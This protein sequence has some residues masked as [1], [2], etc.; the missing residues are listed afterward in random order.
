M[1]A[2]LSNEIRRLPLHEKHAVKG[3]R[4]GAF[5][6]WE[7]PLYYTSILEEH[8]AVRRQAGL[9]DISHM[10]EFFVLGAK[11]ENFLQELLP[12]NLEAVRDGQAKY[13]P[14]LN[15]RGGMVDDI[16]LY[17][18]SKDRFLIIVNAANIEKDFSWI[19]PRVS[20]GVLFENQS[21][22]KG[23]LALQGPE[24]SRILER[25]FGGHFNRLRYY[26]FALWKSGM[27]S[28]TGYTGEDGFEIM[29]DKKDLEEV[30]DKLFAA[31]KG[32]SVLVPVGF[33]AR[34]TLR[35]EAAMPLYGHDM[36]DDVS[37][38]ELGMG[39]A[40]DLNKASFCGRDALLKES[41]QGSR[42][43]LVGFE[44][45][46]RGIP[47]QDCAIRKGSRELG[48]VTS[49]TFAPTLQKNIGLGYVPAEEATVG[50]EIQIIV[51]DKPLK[52]KI[53]KLPFYKRRKE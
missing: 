49:G 22:E 37:P 8:H 44:M 51:R 43:K 40:V 45:V 41:R 23:L 24:S 18:I 31:S 32:D 2:L 39:W 27:I 19:R 34:D 16:V 38:L 6:D 3:A 21:E 17:R 47:R 25:A 36:K 14:L 30:W 50:N 15:E 9:F 35:L 1:G 5:G 10:G 26:E 11:A 13:M 33:G 4:F 46:D 52:A 53:V 12:R 7:V 29:V 28:R 20:A 42:R 48:K